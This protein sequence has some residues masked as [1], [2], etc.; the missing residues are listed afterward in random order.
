[1]AAFDWRQFSFKENIFHF[2]HICAY[3]VL[4]SNYPIRGD[5]TSWDCRL[6]AAKMRQPAPANTGARAFGAESW[7]H[8]QGIL[9]KILYE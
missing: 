8:N 1:M 4:R 5:L 7:H 9:A 6:L 2:R 3:H